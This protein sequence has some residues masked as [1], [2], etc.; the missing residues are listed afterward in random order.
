MTESPILNL[1]ELV[2]NIRAYLV[3]KTKPNDASIIEKLQ[4]RIPV[5]RT[6]QA[7]NTALY[8]IRL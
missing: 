7:R 2:Y 4:V 3:F 5:T 8:F 6:V 1:W